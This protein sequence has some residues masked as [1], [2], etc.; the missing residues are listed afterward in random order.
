MKET[1]GAFPAMSGGIK[2]HA[3]FIKTIPPFSTRNRADWRG[4]WFLLPG[5]VK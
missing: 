1:K 3:E 4:L 2:R 5:M